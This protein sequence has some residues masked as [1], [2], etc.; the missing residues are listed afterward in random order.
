MKTEKLLSTQNLQFKTVIGGSG[1]FKARSILAMFVDTLLI[2]DDTLCAQQGIQYRKA[3]TTFTKD[4]SNIIKVYPNPVLNEIKIKIDQEIKSFVTV[5]ILNNLGQ[6]VFKGNYNEQDIVL[7]QG[8]AELA[9][10]CYN[11]QVFSSDGLLN[12]IV[13]F[14]KL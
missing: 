2:Y 7:K 9:K 11:I 13:K 3:Q 12:H 5:R 14:I 10:G 4:K 1:V 6:E 8:I